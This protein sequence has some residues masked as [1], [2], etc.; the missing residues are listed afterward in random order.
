[1]LRTVVNIYLAVYINTTAGMLSFNSF[2]VTSRIRFLLLGLLNLWVLFTWFTVQSALSNNPYMTR[3]EYKINRLSTNLKQIMN[4]QVIIVLNSRRSL[5]RT[6]ETSISVVKNCISTC[7]VN[8]AQNT[9]T[10]SPAEGLRPFP[11]TPKS[12]GVWVWH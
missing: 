9:L 4:N 5:C 6:W 1:M 7:L 8:T 2:E 3:R 11:S 12:E 10:V